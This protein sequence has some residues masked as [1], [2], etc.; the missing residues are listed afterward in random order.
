MLGRDIETKMWGYVKEPEIQIMRSDIASKTKGYKGTEIY[1]YLK[2][3][4]NLHRMKWVR[5]S[6]TQ[7][8]IETEI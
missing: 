6:K 7:K 2:Y 5:V 3:F 1:H 8:G 4:N